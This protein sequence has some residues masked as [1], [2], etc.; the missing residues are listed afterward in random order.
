MQKVSCFP[1]HPLI[2]LF[3]FPGGQPGY[4]Y[5]H[6]LR[7]TL[8]LLFIAQQCSFLHYRILSHCRMDHS[9]NTFFRQAIFYRTADHFVAVADLG[10]IVYVR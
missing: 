6:P 8:V 10:K 1:E 2:I 5:R 4:D 3:I 9:L 7:R